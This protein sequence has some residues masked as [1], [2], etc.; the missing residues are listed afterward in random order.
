ME[1]LRLD[2]LI[3]HSRALHHSHLVHN[4][5]QT[6]N[7]YKYSRVRGW[8]RDQF[9]TLSL[10]QIDHQGPGSH[11]VQVSGVVDTMRHR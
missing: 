1:G 9:R 10:G 2:A 7:A 5:A 6:I 11:L 3:S 8:S 4:P